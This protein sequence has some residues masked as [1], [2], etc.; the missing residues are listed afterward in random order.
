MAP[1]LENDGYCIV[2]GVLDADE[3]VAA[4]SALAAAVAETERR[5]VPTF[6]PVLDPNP[7]NVR[8]FNLIDLHATFRELI[9]HPRAIQLVTRLLGEHFMISNFTANIARPGSRSMAVHADQAIVVPEPWLSPWAINIIWCLTD[10]TA[11]N[12]GTLFLPGSHKVTRRSE[13]PAHPVE[14]MVAF[15]APA[16]SV[17]AMDGRL[18]HT[19]G[20]NV[21]TDEERSLLFGYY[22]MDFIRPQVNWN[23]ILSDETMAEVSPALSARLGL[24]PSANVRLG[25]GLAPDG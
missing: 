14:N 22:T 6:M 16:G 7:A 17:V 19:S 5:G 12:G 3:V 18:W 23:A 24:G 8:V 1:D 2:E 4:R 11:E 9:L 25:A 10:V 21:T 20:A 15:E 13:L